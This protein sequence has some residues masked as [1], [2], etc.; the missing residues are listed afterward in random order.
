MEASGD[1]GCLQFVSVDLIWEGGIVVLRG[2]AD[3]VLE[4]S[5]IRVWDEGRVGT[6][7]RV[8]WL[9]RKWHAGVRWQGFNDGVEDFIGEK[10]R[11]ESCLAP[12]CSR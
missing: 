7:V 10:I 4:G 11:R 3:Q 1:G 9:R 2:A 12:D 8:R 5:F 6:A